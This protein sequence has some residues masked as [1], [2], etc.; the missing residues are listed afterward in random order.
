MATVEGYYSHPHIH[1]QLFPSLHDAQLGRS[2]LGALG[3][4][5]E[6]N[7]KRVFGLIPGASNAYND[8][9]LLIQAKA[10]EGAEQAIPRIKSEVEA[11]V[12]PYVI[13]AFLFGLGGF[14]LGLSTYIQN[15]RG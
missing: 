3:A 13:A 15:R 4:S 9:V 1:A 2:P 14:M 11:T 10:K 8:L 6:D 12:K 7:L 5:F